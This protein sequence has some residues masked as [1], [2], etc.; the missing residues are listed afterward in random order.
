M[1]EKLESLI[2]Q[3]HYAVRVAIENHVDISTLT[4]E[5]Q[6]KNIEY[7]QQEL[8]KL[9]TNRYQFKLY[10]KINYIAA[11]KRDQLY[12]K[13]IN[14]H[15]EI[16]VFAKKNIYRSSVIRDLVCHR[17]QQVKQEDI[18]LNKLKNVAELFCFV[19][20]P[21]NKKSMIR[22]LQFFQLYGAGAFINCACEIHA[23]VVPYSLFA[24][25]GLHT[26]YK[27]FST[28]RSIKKDEEL[29]MYYGPDYQLKCYVCFP[30]AME[31]TE[32]FHT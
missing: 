2:A 14:F 28:T 12:Y 31:I 19:K 3:V 18:H 6:D 29:L 1:S 16:G 17:G 25:K 15:T 30:I 23:N 21:N 13:Y 7:S 24:A 22:K 27:A 20:N 5:N 32:Y 26:D 4:L 8:N 9:K 11:I 10:L